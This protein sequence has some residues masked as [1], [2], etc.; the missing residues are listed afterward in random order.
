MSPAPH[1]GSSGDKK[2]PR[3]GSSGGY[4]RP[5][6]GS[7]G[8]QEQQHAEDVGE[9]HGQHAPARLGALRQPPAASASTAIA[10]QIWPGVQ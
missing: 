1:R 2:K 10:E 3:G 4:G 7:R 8:G 5:Q 6:Q 9:E